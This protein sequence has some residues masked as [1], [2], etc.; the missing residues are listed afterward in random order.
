[1][2]MYSQIVWFFPWLWTP[3]IMVDICQGRWTS[4]SVQF[5]THLGSSF[6]QCFFFCFKNLFNVLLESV[7][8]YLSVLPSSRERPNQSKS[9]I[10]YSIRCQRACICVL[11]VPCCE[12]SQNKTFS[13]MHTAGLMWCVRMFLCP[14]TSSFCCLYWLHDVCSWSAIK[15]SASFWKIYNLVSSNIQEVVNRQNQSLLV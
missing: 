1:M 15:L 8:V 2:Q 12:F 6:V 10:L 14:N 5:T 4:Q 13:D 7:P 3:N 9:N 11:S